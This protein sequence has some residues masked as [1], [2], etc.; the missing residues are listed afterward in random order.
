MSLRQCLNTFVAVAGLL[1]AVAVSAGV[2]YKYQNLDGSIGYGD[3]LPEGAFLVDELE[4]VETEAV[5]AMAT[6][7]ELIDQ[8]SATADRLQKDRQQ[9]DAQR[10]AAEQARVEQQQSAPVV[11]YREEHYYPYLHRRSYRNDRK[12]RND[13]NYRN[14]DHRYPDVYRQPANRL[15]RNDDRDSSARRVLTPNKPVLTP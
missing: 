1:M 7:S 2:V 11:I 10:R 12:Y 5:E 9:R 15:P 8:L 4:M 3:R 14:R 13:R 6:S